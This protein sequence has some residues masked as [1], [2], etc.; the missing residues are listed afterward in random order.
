MIEQQLRSRLHIVKRS[1]DIERALHVR[2]FA[3]L[4]ET[5]AQ[6]HTARAELQIAR[7]DSGRLM[8]VLATIIKGLEEGLPP[9]DIW[10]SARASLGLTGG[11]FPCR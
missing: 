11:R 10:R 3:E 1:R 5:K 8:T 9:E 7:T 6:L 4:S 2:H